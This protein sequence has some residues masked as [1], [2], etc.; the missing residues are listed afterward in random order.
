MVA[1]C[2]LS[3]P[4]QGQTTLLSVST[5]D[6]TDVKRMLWGEWVKF[7]SPIFNLFVVYAR[8]KKS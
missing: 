4:V 3:Q 7:H 6:L 2:R 8:I 5:A 1:T